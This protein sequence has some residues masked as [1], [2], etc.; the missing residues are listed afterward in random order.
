M[1]DQERISFFGKILEEL[2]GVTKKGWQKLLF[3][4][5][6]TKQSILSRSEL[7]TVDPLHPNVHE[8]P[9]SLMLYPSDAPKDLVPVQVYGDG[10]CLFRS[11]SV[12]LF[13]HERFHV[14]M[15]VRT[16]FEL[17]TNFREY[18]KEHTFTSMSS[19][20]VSLQYVLETSFSHECYVN[21]NYSKSLQN[22][23]LKS[24]KSGE[25]A[26]LIH[27]YALANSIKCQINSISP[28]I[29]NPTID[30]GVHN[31]LITPVNS[32]FNMT[33]N[34]MWTHTSNHATFNWTPN[35][36][37]GCIKREAPPAASDEPTCSQKATPSS[38]KSTPKEETKS[39][40]KETSSNDDAPPSPP[41]KQK[42]EDDNSRNMWET[43]DIGK[44]PFQPKNKKFPSSMFGGRARSFL[45]TWFDRWDW[46]HYEEDSDRAFC[47]V[48]IK[49]YNEKNISGHLFEKKHL[50]LLDLT[51]GKRR[52]T[53]LLIMK[54]ANATK[55]Q[56][57]GPSSCQ[58]QPRI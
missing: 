52:H 32:P 20:V 57:K 35:H 12:L 11:I 4:V 31:Q 37:V 43:P 46:L 41:K 21:G 5:N 53:N 13:G 40:S 30:R 27:I 3:Y 10:N 8:D 45:G 6:L 15:R 34:L 58:N 39:T 25:Y 44:Q 36:F 54:K 42:R 33:I 51:T 19:N 23:I 24:A 28:N 50:F 55:R 38:P 26:S 22:E 7:P 29:E 9:T 47:F 16:T 17:V 1:S 48:C 49:A 2:S 18:L 14:E 56:R